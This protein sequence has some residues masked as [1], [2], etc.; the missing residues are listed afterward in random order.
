VCFLLGLLGGLTSR[1]F[2]GECTSE[3]TGLLCAKVNSNVLLAS[4]CSAGLR[5]GLLV[6][7][8]KDASDGLA[9]NFDLGELRNSTASNLCDTK[10]RQIALQLLKLREKLSL[11]LVPELVCLNFN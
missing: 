1:F 6:V 9:N 5:L 10:R 11:I 8:G 4:R 2:L 7:D 3:S